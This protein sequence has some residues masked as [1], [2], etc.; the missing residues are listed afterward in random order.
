M[1]TTYKVETR[2][3]G[4]KYDTRLTTTNETQAHLIYRG[5]N[6]G[7]GYTKRLTADGVTIKKFKGA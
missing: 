3:D 5:Y 7:N 4:R 6:I 2:K 1:E